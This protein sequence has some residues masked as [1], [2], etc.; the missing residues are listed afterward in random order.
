MS[1]ADEL[2]AAVPPPPRF[3][4]TVQPEV[5]DLRVL[6]RL[7][8]NARGVNSD[9]ALASLIGRYMYSDL[10]RTLS[11][12]GAERTITATR[13]DI[14]AAARAVKGYNAVFG[15]PQSDK[16]GDIREAIGASVQRYQANGNVIDPVA[17]RQYLERTPVE[18]QT[19]IYI[20]QLENM[21]AELRATG[22]PAA[23][24]RQARRKVL[25]MIAPGQGMSAEELAK[26]VERGT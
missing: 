18:R 16:T 26:V 25:V 23:D 11:E 17:F 3:V 24:Y 13:L 21:L 5:F 12:F 8:I 6:S 7:S 4:D 14:D 2:A 19:L 20:Q 9:E 10:P 15:T 22:L 1:I